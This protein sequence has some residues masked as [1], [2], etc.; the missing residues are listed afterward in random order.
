[1]ERHTR[2]TI[3]GAGRAAAAVALALA[4]ALAPVARPAGAQSPDVDAGGLLV[5]LRC[6]GAGVSATAVGTI[7]GTA[8]ALA[9]S[10]AEP[11]HT[12]QVDPTG[13]PCWSFAGAFIYEGQSSGWGG[14]GFGIGG[15]ATTIGDLGT[16]SLEIMRPI[17]HH[18]GVT[19]PPFPSAAGGTVCSP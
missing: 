5:I 8:V 4:L 16:V 14:S 7:G 11:V 17:Y 1:M 10:E 2:Y 19:S 18:P 13:P 6:E 12:L 15:T 3:A 9:C